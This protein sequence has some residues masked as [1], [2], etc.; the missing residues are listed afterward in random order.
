MAVRGLDRGQRAALIVS[1]CQRGILDTELA[2]FPGL[3]EQAHA[4]GALDRAAWLAERF[5]EAGRLVVFAHVVHRPGFV[6]FATTSPIA[7]SSRRGNRMVAG[8][9][10]VAPMPPLVPQ[11]ADHVST[12]H[13]GLGMWYG[14]DLDST[15]RNERV[16]T[17]VYA[18]VSTNVALFA[19]SIGATDRGYQAVIAEDASAGATAEGH[20]WMI[21][22]TL[23]LIATVASSEDIAAALAG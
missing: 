2:V 11:A 18:G 19:G 8:S 23:P 22:N 14:T 5:R 10:D 15:L 17:V 13:S 4:R 12:R 20:E 1:E 9:A 7:G 16:E 21:T 6:G 3:A